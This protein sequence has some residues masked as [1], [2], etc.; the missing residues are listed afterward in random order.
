MPSN[1]F[2]SNLYTHINSYIAIHHTNKNM[3][4]TIAIAIAIATTTPSRTLA[5]LILEKTEEE[6]V[7]EKKKS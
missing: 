5:H 7:E 2:Q 6:S 4:N 3:K 1:Q